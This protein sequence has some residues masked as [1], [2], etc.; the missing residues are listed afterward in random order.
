MGTICRL[1]VIL[2]VSAALVLGQSRGGSNFAWYGLTGCNRDPWYALANYDAD[3]VTIDAALNQLYQNGQRKLRLPIFHNTLGFDCT[4]P[5]GTRSTQLLS[6]GG[7]LTWQCS[8]NLQGLLAKIAS[9]G[10]EEVE[11]GFFPSGPNHPGS[12]PAAWYLNPYYLNLSQENW[13]LIA[14][15]VPLLNAS[16]LDYKID[17]MN[18]GIPNY[19]ANNRAWKQAQQGWLT[20][21]QWLW[22]NYRSVFGI[23]RTVGYSVA[24]GGGGYAEYNLAD[25]YGWTFPPVFDIHIYDDPVGTYLSVWDTL[26]ARGQTQGWII[27]E[28]Y[29]NNS[30]SASGLMDAKIAAGN[31]TF[32]LAQWP[33]TSTRA[34]SDVDVAPPTDFSEYIAAGW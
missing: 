27:G 33:L 26:Q 16:G 34:C 28:T 20:Y 8:Q 3:S 29:Y 32:W 7:G 10:F 2:P 11:V 24:A 13:N 4:G 21:V 25:V 31:T 9:L 12:W 30:S 23:S 15:L 14:G 17:L 1:A 19:A 5:L 22:N 18:E 6:A